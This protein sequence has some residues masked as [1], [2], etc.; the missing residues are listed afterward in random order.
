MGSDRHL[1]LAILWLQ[2]AHDA[3]PTDQGVSAYYSMVGGWAPAYPEISGYIISTFL[4][5]FHLINN[6]QS[7]RRALEL[8]NWLVTIQFDSGAYQEGKF[9]GKPRGP[10]VFN[11]GQIMLGLARAYEETGE[12]RFLVAIRRAANWLVSVQDGD[13]AWRKYCYGGT[14]HT[15]YTRVAWALLQAYGCIREERFLEAA[16]RNLDWTVEQQR[17]NGWFDNC[18]FEPEEG[19]FL[20][21]IAYTIRGLLESGLATGETRY[22]EP[23]RKAADVLSQKERRGW[24]A[25]A[26]DQ[27]WRGTKYACLTGQAQTSIIWFKL[28]NHLGNSAYL[29][30]ALAV[31]NFLKGCQTLRSSD[32]A[33]VGGLKGS[34]PIWGRYMPLRY[35]AWAVKFF[36]DALMLEI[37]LENTLTRKANLSAT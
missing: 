28:W 15:Y 4:D 5:H 36:A 16:C 3:T 32:A 25:G 6:R 26:Y 10:S 21:T 13:G 2:K 12:E 24:L 18:F 17:E 22:I 30:K 8:A 14:A 9:T 31:S 23:A 7:R 37:K 29:E 19:T 34:I 27:N 11:T 20:H 33:L 35:T 1:E